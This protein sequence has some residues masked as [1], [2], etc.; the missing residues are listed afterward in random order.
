MNSRR[1]MTICGTYAAAPNAGSVVH[2][3]NAEETL[4]TLSGLWSS[5]MPQYSVKM[6]NERKTFSPRR[7]PRY[8]PSL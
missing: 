3:N 8:S 4:T 1:S 5:P 2:M 7:G 6:R